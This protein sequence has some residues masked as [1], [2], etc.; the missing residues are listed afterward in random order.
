MSA[1]SISSNPLGYTGI[2]FSQNPPLIQASRAPTSND[3][4][5]IGTQWA[6]QAVNPPVI[7]ETTGNGVWNVGANAYA[8]TTSAGIVQ[9]S[10]SIAGDASSTTLVPTVK[11]IKD[12]VDGV[13]I[14]GAPGATT[15]VAG[16]GQ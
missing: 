15:L 3:M 14:A 8:T 10:S 9:L 4:Y 11:E 6:N 2:N 5:P 7:Y 12:Y 13:A 16:I 1:S